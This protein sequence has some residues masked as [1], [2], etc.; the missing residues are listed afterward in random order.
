M[1]EI[2]YLALG[3]NLGDSQSILQDAIAAI[4]NHSDIRIV[5]TSSFY[6]SKPLG[7]VAQHD[8]VNMVVEVAT[9]LLPEQLLEACLR[10]E[11]SF[12]RIRKAR[13]GDRTLDID[14]IDYASLEVSLPQL[15]LPHPRTNERDFVLLPL[16][17]ITDKNYMLFGEAVGWHLERLSDMFVY[18]KESLVEDVV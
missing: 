5:S 18:R 14:I 4:D 10:I 8:F 13:W 17:E 2:A 16:A 3:S 7:G 11:N 9:T 6:F 12:G 1:S 15:E